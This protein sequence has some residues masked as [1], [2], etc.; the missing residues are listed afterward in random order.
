MEILK[1][2]VVSFQNGMFGAL[3][4]VKEPVEGEEKF[5]KQRQIKEVGHAPLHTRQSIQFG[6][7]LFHS[8]AA[9]R[10]AIEDYW[11]YEHR[12]FSDFKFM[13]IDYE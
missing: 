3:A 10:N 13:V 11:K 5:L 12:D 9:V 6:E 8:I 2:E 7:C 1:F 4:I